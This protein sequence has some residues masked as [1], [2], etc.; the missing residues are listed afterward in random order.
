MDW[1]GSVVSAALPGLLPARFAA[2]LRRVLFL[3]A[4]AHS[5]LTQAC[6][7][8]HARAWVCACMRACMH[9]RA[10]ARAYAL[11]C[12][13]DHRLSRAKRL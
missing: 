12:V 11:T 2:L 6:A 1:A 13:H 5:Y 3:E 8:V 9:A 4:D 7:R 10:R